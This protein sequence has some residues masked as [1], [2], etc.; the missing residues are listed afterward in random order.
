M[1]NMK[2]DDLPR[3]EELAYARKTLL[4]NPISQAWKKDI[5][6]RKKT[7]IEEMFLKI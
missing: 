2:C 7:D 4:G 1:S 6:K 5:Q 3:I